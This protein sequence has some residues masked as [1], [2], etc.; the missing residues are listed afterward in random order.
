MRGN[1]H[2]WHLVSGHLAHVSQCALLS[3]IPAPAIAEDLTA[4]R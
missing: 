4:W 2:I 3:H 1:V